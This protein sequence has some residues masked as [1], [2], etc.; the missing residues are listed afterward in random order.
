MKVVLVSDTH[1]TPRTAAFTDNWLAA[2]IWIEATAPSLVVNL[3]DITADGAHDPHELEAARSA[4]ADLSAEMRFVPG[5]HDI[6]DNP[7]EPGALNEH[8]LDLA[9]LADYRRLFGP[10]QWTLDAA[11]WQLVGLNAQL[12]GTGTVEEEQQF[13]WLAEQ[14]AQRSGPLGVMLHKPLFRNGPSDTEAHIRYV[15]AAPRHRLLDCLAP[16]DLR[17]VVSGH[18]HQ[19]RSLRVGGVEHMWAPS[20]AYCIPDARQE[21]IG[22]KIVGLLTLDLTE[23]DHRFELVT[24]EGMVQHSI[25]DYPEVYAEP[26]RTTS[27]AEPVR[28][29]RP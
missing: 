6:G 16:R 15:P 25:A 14:L 24:P 26:A 11:P 8:P 23:S 7:L 19:A 12:F 5:N 1:L 27:R 2:R 3:G 4:F 17:F 28:S 29:E 9:R 21:R 13:D 10:D 22:E 20:T 18:V